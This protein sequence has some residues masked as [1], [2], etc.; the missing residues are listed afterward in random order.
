VKQ[1]EAGAC[2]RGKV[3]LGEESGGV[4]AKVPW[5]E[6]IRLGRLRWRV[7]EQGLGQGSEGA[8]RSG[9]ATDKRAA[10]RQGSTSVRQIFMVES[11]FL[12]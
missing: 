1:P 2:D 4:C 8:K 12:F 9:G 3:F 6:E 11:R 10:S 7:G 5:G